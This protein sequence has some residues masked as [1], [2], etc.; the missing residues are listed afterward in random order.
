MNKFDW[1][2]TNISAKDGI[3]KSAQ[4]FCAVENDGV[5]VETQGNWKFRDPEGAFTPYE[6]V[7]EQMVIDWINQEA[8]RDGKNLI[9]SRLEEQLAALQDRTPVVAPWLPQ[10]YTPKI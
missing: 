10:V 5:K 3:I 8:I 9:T 6:E 1:S 2:I 7:T 4:Y